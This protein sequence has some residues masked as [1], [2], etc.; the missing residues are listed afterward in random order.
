MDMR[1][2]VSLWKAKAD[3]PT[4]EQEILSKLRKEG[5]ASAEKKTDPG[6][7]W[8]RAKRNVARL[9]DGLDRIWAAEIPVLRVDGSLF[10]ADDPDS[11]DEQTKLEP[12]LAVL[13]KRIGT[14]GTKLSDEDYAYSILKQIEP[15]VHAMV[16]SLY[17]KEGAQVARL[18]SATDLVMTALRLAAAEYAASNNVPDQV[19][20][21]K[22][23]FHRLIRRDR[24]L[25]DKFLPLLGGPL[26][27]WFE[28]LLRALQY[29]AP[30]NPCGLPKYLFPHLGR[31]LVQVLLRFA[32]IGYLSPELS[33]PRRHDLLR[34]C[35]F[36]LVCVT[37]GDNAS[38]VAY[39]CLADLKRRA[40]HPDDLGYWIAQEIV[41]NRYGVALEYPKDIQEH[42][43]LAFVVPGT[44][45]VVGESR[46]LPASDQNRDR[47]LRSFYRQRWWR[48][49]GYHHPL[50]LWLQRAYVEQIP[51][52]P[53]AGWDEDTAYDYD[54]ILPGAHWSYWTGKS[55]DP[56]R[57]PLFCEN[58]QYNVIGNGIGNVRVW[59]ASDNRSDSD[60]PPAEKLTGTNNN[61]HTAGQD[62]LTDSAI[63]P[64]DLRL[65]CSCSVSKSCPEN[66]TE[67]HRYWDQE[68]ALAF[69]VAVETRAF[70]L[71]KRF[72]DDLRFVDWPNVVG[73]GATGTA[74]LPP[75][76]GEAQP[77]GSLA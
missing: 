77:Q 6:P 2:L 59:D 65:W 75:A 19:R 35:L 56:N 39:T 55:G 64:D 62:I 54:H 29:D 1:E 76:A 51:G 70:K 60:R 28:S 23:E 57:L 17:S 36:W 46:F 49:W 44:K 12:P 37:N 11:A 4:Y 7:I 14:N 24:F 48:P 32:Q 63:E 58:N 15:N 53:L 5:I 67:K 30:T 26:V 27:T 74:R 13:F 31:Q 41:G 33:E 38:R 68:R 8:E 50:L 52:E 3:R 34:F 72:F 42:P 66:V 18:M 10:R 45:K 71:Y 20:P 25:Y 40:E 21:K 22:E 9:A 69:Q 43:G 16:E 47:A 73:V 61:R